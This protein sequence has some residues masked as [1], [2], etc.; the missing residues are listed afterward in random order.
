MMP[1]DPDRHGPH[2]IV[3]PGFHERVFALVRE[4]PEGT[5]T[6]YGD[7]ARALGSVRV[8]RHVGYALAALPARSRDVP[9]FRVVNGRGRLHRGSDEPGGK[10]QRRRL[11]REGIAVD[12]AGKIE[13]FSAV[14]FR[15][16]D[17]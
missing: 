11:R 17:D 4:V 1:Y 13:G 5:V 8:A 16:D 10:D 14:R 6:T 7:I 3:G 15:F 2:R 9:W 12:D